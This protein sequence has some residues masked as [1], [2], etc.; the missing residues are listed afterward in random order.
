MFLRKILYL[1]AG[2]LLTIVGVVVTPMPIPIPL[3][4]LLPLMAGLAILIN[5]SRTMRRLIQRARHRMRWFS[6]ML[7]HFAHRAPK[8]IR[9]ILARSHPA[10]IERHARINT[11]PPGDGES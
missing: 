11:R 4:G 3:V 2:W 6:Y 5:H 10:S 8:R 7:E 9:A 1:T